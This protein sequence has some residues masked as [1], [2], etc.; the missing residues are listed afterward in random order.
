MNRIRREGDVIIMRVGGPDEWAKSHAIRD[1][2][3]AQWEAEAAQNE[4]PNNGNAPKNAV[5][6]AQTLTVKV[7]GKDENEIF[8]SIMAH[9]K[10]LAEGATLETAPALPEICCV[11]SQGNSAALGDNDA[12]QIMNQDQP[13]EPVPMKDEQQP[14]PPKPKVERVKKDLPKKK[15]RK[16]GL[17]KSTRN[18]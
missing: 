1:A 15:W 10:A 12:H 14:L 6:E 13:T 11:E 16:Q 5:N 4:A 17:R 2:F 3:I 18:R 7:G 9:H 8:D